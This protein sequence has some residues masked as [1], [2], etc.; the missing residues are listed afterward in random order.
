M[1]SANLLPT[2]V[3]VKT[4]VRNLQIGDK[5]VGSGFVVRSLPRISGRKA[6]LDG[7]YFLRNEQTV[8]WN[9]NTTVTVERVVWTVPEPQV[10]PSLAVLMGHGA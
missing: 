3:R 4:S 10:V 8:E 1:K 7:H 2:I 9:A 6:Q 5:L